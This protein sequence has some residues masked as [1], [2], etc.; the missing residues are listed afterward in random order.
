MRSLFSILFLSLFFSC[1]ESLNEN[2][3]KYENETNFT[4]VRQVTF[5]GDNAEAYWSFDDKNLV[6]QS[7]FLKTA[8][9]HE[10]IYIYIYV[11]VRVGTSKFRPKIDQ[12]SVKKTHWRETN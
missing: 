7:T 9:P 8:K 2:N 10:S 4:S 5:G 12:K 3:L 6:F 11:F 1:S